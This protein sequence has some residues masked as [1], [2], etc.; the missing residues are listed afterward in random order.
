MRI[1]WIIKRFICKMIGCDIRHWK[2]NEYVSGEYCY[3]CEANEDTIWN[4]SPFQIV[5]RRESFM[6]RILKDSDYDD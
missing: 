3:R 6:G 1:K 4:E 5:K 2:E